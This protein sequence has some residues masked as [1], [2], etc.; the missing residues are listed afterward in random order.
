MNVK[1]IYIYIYIQMFLIVPSS[2]PVIFVDLV[3]KAD[4]VHNGEFEVDVAL[5]QVVRPRAQVDTVL[6]VAGLLILKHGVEER[7]H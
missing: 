1:K 5:L 2:S 4:G 3:A 6:V 7:V